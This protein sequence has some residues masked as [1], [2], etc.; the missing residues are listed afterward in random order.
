M[1]GR[2]A[3]V[4]TMGWTLVHYQGGEGEL[5]DLRNDPHELVSQYDNPEVAPVRAALTQKLVS[6]LVDAVPRSP[7]TV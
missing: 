3:M 1:R 6:S 2:M 4:R 5:Y 7:S